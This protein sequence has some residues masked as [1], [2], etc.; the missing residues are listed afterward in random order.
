MKK[1]LILIAAIFLFTACDSTDIKKHVKSYKLYMEPFK[2]M[3]GCQNIKLKGIIMVKD[4]LVVGQINTKPYSAIR[5]RGAYKDSSQEMAVDFL[6]IN[7]TSLGYA[8]G[9]L[10][11]NGGKGSWLLGRC[12]GNW[13]AVR[14]Q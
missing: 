5:F 9:K 7:G 10:E 8:G 12:E 13:V 1:L 3:D 2:G 11:T 6:D 4:S 14:E